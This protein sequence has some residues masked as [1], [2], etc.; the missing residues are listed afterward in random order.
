MCVNQLV[1]QRSYEKKD[2]GKGTFE[3]ENILTQ[4]WN[5]LRICQEADVQNGE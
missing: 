2:S 4:I 5:L 1:L 3:L